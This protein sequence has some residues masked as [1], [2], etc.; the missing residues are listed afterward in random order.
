[1]S[2]VC[3]WIS[4]RLYY[5]PTRKRAM[6]LQTMSRLTDLLECGWDLLFDLV[7]C[8]THSRAK[9]SFEEKTLPDGRPMTSQM[10]SRR[11]SL[12]C[13]ICRVLSMQHQWPMH[14]SCSFSMRPH[15]WKL[16]AC[17]IYFSY[18]YHWHSFYCQREDGHWWEQ[19]IWWDALLVWSG[20]GKSAASPP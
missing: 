4:M 14:H 5:D 3:S 1:M 9:S 2:T 19:R 17:S 20:L 6:C 11:I 16:D 18:V 8:V 12:R 7:D 10:I 15:R 13:R